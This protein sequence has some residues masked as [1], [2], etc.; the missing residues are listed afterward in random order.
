MLLP[1]ELCG[2]GNN[3]EQSKG[4]RKK[5]RGTWGAAEERYA[6]GIDH[7]FRAGIL[8]LNNG[9][10]SR[11][12][13]ADELNCEPMRITKKRGKGGVQMFPA[14]KFTA[15]PGRMFSPEHRALAA[16]QR[17]HL[18]TLFL[19]LDKNSDGALTIDEMVEGLKQS[20]IKDGVLFN[21]NFNSFYHIKS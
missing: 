8:P 20:G 1:T 14:I 21:Y 12:Y 9:V 18:R 5:R 4:T 17:D 7:H 6:E 13:L 10:S 19:Q 16:N 2:G 11:T 15:A 3:N